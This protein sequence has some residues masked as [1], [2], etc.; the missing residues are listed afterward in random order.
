[1][2]G[3]QFLVLLIAIF[4]GTRLKGIGLGLMGGLGLAILTFVFCLK[5]TPPPIEVLIIVMTIS[6]ASGTLEVAGGMHYLTSLAER[7]IRKYPHRIIFISPLAAY[8]LAFFGGTGHTVYP[9]LP[10]VAEVARTIGIKPSR[11]LSVAVIASQQ[12]A[13]ASPISGPT[14]IVLG[15][16]AQYEVGIMDI[17]KICIPATLGGVFL[18]TFLVNRLDKNLYGDP[19]YLKK[20]KAYPQETTLSATES[21]PITNTAKRSVGLFFMGISLIFLL[22]FFK[23]LRPSWEVNGVMKTLEMPTVTGI[24][25]LSVAALIVL[26]CEADPKKIIASSVFKA[27]IQAVISILGIA[28]LSTTF[29]VANQSEIQAAFQG[30]LTKAPWQFSIVLFLASTILANHA[31]TLISIIP[32]GVSIGL[33]APAILAA[34]PAVNGIFFLANYPTILAAISFDKTGTTRVGKFVL[35][36]SFMMPGLVATGTAIVIAGILAKV[37]F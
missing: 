37:V 5:P 17:L 22:G 26:L 11:P 1:M 27:G 23:D 28:W 8:L 35:N 21:Y 29:F 10:V 33:S 19:E 24:M 36:H 30:Q 25:M 9:I 12:A 16:L 15:L 2:I 20:A 34:L 6:I 7:L 31:G 32:L 18:A 13:I 14:A 4:L 3:V